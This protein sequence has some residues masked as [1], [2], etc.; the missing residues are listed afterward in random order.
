MEKIKKRFTILSLFKSVKTTMLILFSLLIVITMFIFL[1]VSLNYTERTVVENSTDYTSRLT[2]Q[3]N[4]DIDSY[5]DYMKNISSMVIQGGDVQ[6][7]LFTG[8]TKAGEQEAYERI[9][10]QFNTVLETRQDIS[11]I[12]VVT[13]DGR[14]II[15]DGTDR[16]NENIS[17]EDVDWYDKALCGRESVLTSSHVQHM[18]RNNYQWVVT[19]S[20]GIENPVTKKN[21]GV[22]FI[23]LNYRLLKDLCEN[24]SPAASSYVFIMD[25]EGKIIYHP[26]QQ[27]LYNG[28]KEEKTDEVLRC[29]QGHFITREGNESRLYTV[30]VSDKTGWRVVGVTQLSELMKNKKEMQGTYV[31]MAVLLLGAAMVLSM[32]FATAITRPIKELRDSMKEVEKGN[33]DNVN[34]A[35]S[36]KTEIGSLENSFNLMTS[37]I[38]QLMEQNIYEQEQKRQSEL[39]A[40]RSQINPHFLYNTLDS[41]I[42]MAEGGKNKEV[43][44]MTAALARLLRQSISNDNELISIEKEINYAGSYLTIQKMRYRDKLEYEIEVD[45]EIKHKEIINLILQPLVENAIYHGIKYRGSKGLVRITGRGEGD[46]IILTVSDNGIGMDE[47]AL[48]E[49]FDRSKAREGN[50]GVGVYNVQ[51]RIQ[52]YYGTEYGLHFESRLGEGT[53][54]TVTIPKHCREEG[55]AEHE[56][57]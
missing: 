45:E 12:G 13:R 50:N 47:T 6:K 27:L 48:E 17:L 22:F 42:W 14:Y 52:L 21:E 56:Q 38:R 51:T 49:I 46:K 11:N 35:V 33:L 5:I 39:K 36:S 23:D 55:R 25:G 44:R 41:I 24:N 43:V 37:Q 19:L 8:Q 26:K 30:S 10:T 20:K 7:Y 15:N 57:A 16:L 40:L 34:V 3:V 1:L 29:G 9:I 4:R 32:F 31:L 53:Q 54:V 18:I 2:S 28:L